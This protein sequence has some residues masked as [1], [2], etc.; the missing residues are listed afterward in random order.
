MS[1]FVLKVGDRILQGVKSFYVNSRTHV[2]EH[3]VIILEGSYSVAAAL[4]PIHES[5]SSSTITL[6]VM[7]I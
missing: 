3:N 7:L 6:C 4:S 5:P 2:K 1:K